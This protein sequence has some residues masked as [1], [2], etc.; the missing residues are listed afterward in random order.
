MAGDNVVPIRPW[1]MPTP[2]LDPHLQGL[3]NEINGVND[4]ESFLGGPHLEIGQVYRHPQETRLL[5]VSSGAYLRNGRISNWWTWTYVDPMGVD[6][7]DTGE[8]YGWAG[9]PIDI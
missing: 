2:E 6:T 5:R 8:G 7:D 3:I 1:I 4:P 9:E